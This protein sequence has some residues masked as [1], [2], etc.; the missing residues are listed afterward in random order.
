MKVNNILLG[1]VM[2]LVI[3]GTVEAFRLPFE[4]ELD[5]NT[6]LNNW[7]NHS[8]GEN[9]TRG[10]FTSLNVTEMANVGALNATNV[11]AQLAFFSENVAFTDEFGDTVNVVG[12]MLIVHNAT[13]SDDHA[14][15]LDCNALGFGDVKCI[16]IV[17]ITGSIELGQDE[18]AILINIDGFLATGGDV[19]GVE[20]VTTD[21][22]ATVYG[23]EVGALV[24]PILQ[25]SG[26]FADMDSALVNGV[27]NLSAFI[28]E[29][30]DVD[31]F[32][33]DN[34][35]VTI[36]NSVKFEEIEFILNRTSSN[37][38]IKPTFEFSTGINTW[39]EFFPSDGTNGIRNNGVVIWL[40]EDIPTWELGAG[41]E[42]LIKIT[43]TQNNIVTTPIENFVQIA[44][45][46][47][48]NW[49]KEGDIFIRRLNASENVTATNVFSTT[50][51]QNGVLLNDIYCQLTGCTM[52]GDLIIEGGA[53]NVSE[54]VNLSNTLFTDGSGDVGIGISDPIKDLQIHSP[55][56]TIRLSDSNAGTDQLVATLI[57][58]YRGDN[59]NRVA[60]WGM[61]S[62]SNDIM[63][64]ATDYA[65]GIIELKT[66]SNVLALEIDASQNFDFQDGNIETTGTLAAG[67]TAITGEIIHL[68]GNVDFNTLAE[69]FYFKVK[70][71]LGTALFING[72]SGKVG[73]GTISP[74]VEL[75]VDGDINGT[76]LTVTEILTRGIN[77]TE[78]GGFFSAPCASG[79][80]M[81][82]IEDNG[83]YVCV[84]FS[85]FGPWDNDSVHTFIRSGFPTNVTINNLTIGEGEFSTTYC[86]FFDGNNNDGNFCWNELNDRFLFRDDINMLGGTQT[87]YGHDET[88]IQGQD[89]ANRDLALSAFQDAHII[90]NGD[91]IGTFNSAGFTLNEDANFMG[92]TVHEGDIN[93]SNDTVL[94]FGDDNSFNVTY[95]SSAD[96]IKIAGASIQF[97]LGQ[98]L[99]FGGLSQFIRSPTLSTLE[100]G[101]TGLG[102]RIIFTT[103]GAEIL[104]IGI[105]GLVGNEDSSSIRDFRWEGDKN[106][107]AL[108]V[109]ASGDG[110]TGLGMRPPTSGVIPRLSV[111]GSA[112]ASN[113][114]VSGLLNLDRTEQTIDGDTI[115]AT[116]S[117]II[118]DTEGGAGTDDLR[119]INGGVIGSVVIL[120]T[121]DNGRDVVVV[122]AVGNLQLSGNFTLANNRRRIMLLYDGSVWFEISASSN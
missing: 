3:M 16:D 116:S 8:L 62:S 101:V 100:L 120:Q 61:A 108:F 20:I 39:T 94:R 34:D 84:L 105:A 44:S 51:F 122:D 31:I 54:T 119:T 95:D 67:A 76:N 26:I 82:D 32:L 109:D 52:T 80:A 9:G 79:E 25:L 38:G 63:A 59:D 75:D 71:D 78:I 66:G 114:T 37:P 33:N 48:Y 42:Y 45:T 43:R 22:G 28:S 74:S 68:S 36:G 58:L 81:Q 23:I 7:L 6:F 10:N 98:V 92:D 56:P 117:Y 50:F 53:L 40:D 111:N 113:I 99:Y 41:S 29:T 12:T 49:T 77:T 35:N 17:Y 14:L 85:D 118:L 47:E 24:N 97:A 65:A 69:D 110:S 88:F 107:F 57:E 93:T 21:T 87:R 90:I 11:T 27:D 91:T 104:A 83:T 19:V 86:I 60:F 112:N 4:G 1:L 30:E 15:E 121:T 102:P 115:N 89:S 13:E 70:S 55:V 18:E 2:F 5:W 73:I 72:S 46:T 106:S 96:L 103:N 64:L